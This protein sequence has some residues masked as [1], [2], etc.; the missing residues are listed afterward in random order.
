M[1][2]ELKRIKEEIRTENQYWISY[3]NAVDAMTPPAVKYWTEV[4]NRFYR[5]TVDQEG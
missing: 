2:K 4:F 3:Y 5:S 1:N